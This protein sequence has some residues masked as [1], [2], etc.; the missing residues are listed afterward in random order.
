MTKQALEIIFSGLAVV[1]R[2]MLH[3]HLGDGE[4]ANGRNDQELVKETQSVDTT[5]VEA[6]RDFGML[7]KL[8]KLKAKALDI[9]HESIIMFTGNKTG[10]W[11]DKL[12]RENLKKAMNFARNSKK[13]QKLV[14]LA[15][16]KHIQET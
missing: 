12:S 7:G 9:V 5:I 13:Q 2:Q 16:K 6:E 14:Y 15:K 4:F 8:M 3:D 11:R 10:E 1:T